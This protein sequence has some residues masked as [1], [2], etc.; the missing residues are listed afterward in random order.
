MK[1]AI[2]FWV[3]DVVFV[4]L[5]IFFT[6]EAGTF[7][8]YIATCSIFAANDVFTAASNCGKSWQELPAVSRNGTIWDK[9]GDIL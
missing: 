5:H 4:L 9:K 1:T 8:L 3:L 6:F 2:V 7:D